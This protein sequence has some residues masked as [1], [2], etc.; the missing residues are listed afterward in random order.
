MSGFRLDAL[1]PGIRLLYAPYADLI[2]DGAL[3]APPD[4][5]RLFDRLPPHGFR[6]RNAAGRTLCFA[7]PEAA[8]LGRYELRIRD[9][10][11]V[12]T[13][14]GDWHDYFNALVW[15]VFPLAKAT[16]NTLHCA[17]ID[18]AGVSRRG[19]LRDALTLFDECGVLVVS[20]EVDLLDDLRAHRWEQVFWDSRQRLLPRVRF[21]VFGHA[22][23]DA[24]RAPFPGLCAKALYREVAA[25]WFDLARADALIEADRWL[26]RWLDRMAC[27]LAPASFAPLPIMG[28]PG[29]TPENADPVYYRDPSQF[30][31]RRNDG[32][33]GLRC[34]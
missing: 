22:T 4:P 23:L 5:A 3:E 18:R 33:S 15:H 17:D 25:G 32:L 30:C 29:V 27:R 8:D 10:A 12:A 2:G 34:V 9:H 1:A 19:P 7:A 6:P 26:A 24:L 21:L 31:A 16:I 28:V 11:R 14:A 20:S 13:R